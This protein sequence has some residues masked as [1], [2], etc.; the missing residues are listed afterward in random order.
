MP[1]CKDLPMGDLK[2]AATPDAHP[3]AAKS[4][5][6]LSVLNKSNT[7]LCR[8]TNWLALSPIL[9]PMKIIGPS[10]PAGKLAATVILNRLLI[11]LVL[12]EV[13]DNILH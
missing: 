1:I 4:L 10:S 2:A 8:G 12:A 6:C 5:L 3:I 11:N 7:G 13:G 9:N